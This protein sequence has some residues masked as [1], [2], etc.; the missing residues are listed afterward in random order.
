M[1]Y[2]CYMNLELLEEWQEISPDGRS[3]GIIRKF[4][5][6]VVN[7]RSVEPV[8][9]EQT[10]GRCIKG[11][12]IPTG[13][14][15]YR[16]RC[17]A[18]YWSREKTG[19][20]QGCGTCMERDRRQ[21]TESYEPSGRGGAKPRLGLIG[22]KFGYV[23][24]TGHQ[25]GKG[26]EI[27]C[28]CGRSRYISGGTAISRGSYKTCG[29]C[30]HEERHLPSMAPPSALRAPVVAAISARLDNA[31]IIGTA[32]DAGTMAECSLDHAPILYDPALHPDG[33][34]LC[35]ASARLELAL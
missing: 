11:D 17:K 6:G 15:R 18:L 26:W 24:V 7:K 14:T 10:D 33:C 12:M 9:Y 29:Q 8:E 2:D 19:E 27:T 23:E 25:K 32:I 1:M 16:C 13:W 22:Q 5:G 21:G 28:A 34:P 35:I 20:A 31:R 3:P 4:R 30:T